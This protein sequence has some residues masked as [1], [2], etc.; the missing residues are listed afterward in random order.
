MAAD[1][2]ANGVTIAR[3]Y[4]TV[5]RRRPFVLMSTVLYCGSAG[6][7]GRDDQTGPARPP[8]PPCGRPCGTEE[9]RQAAGPL[10][11]GST[12]ALG[13]SDSGGH[14][15]RQA[16]GH[17]QVADKQQAAGRCGPSRSY[18]SCPNKDRVSRKGRD[19]V[20]STWRGNC[21]ALAQ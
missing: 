10:P 13:Q 20:R 12:L 6:P 16:A 18:S 3:L 5:H 19:S 7:G 14:M 11:A 15:I 21:R 4:T 17:R 8:P 9:G 2:V 1:G